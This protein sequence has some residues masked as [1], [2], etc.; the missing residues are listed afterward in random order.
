MKT[1]VAVFFFFTVVFAK[2]YAFIES[3]YSLALDKT[4][5]QKGTIDFGKDELV[6]YY[7]KADAKICYKEG[8]VEL[9]RGGGRVELDTSQEIS[10]AKL[11]GILLKLYNNNEAYLE[12]FFTISKKPG[13]VIYTAKEKLKGYVTSIEKYSSAGEVKKI[14]IFLTNG[15]IL[16]LEIEHEVS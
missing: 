14:T 7:D 6:I 3:R 8:A 2:E 13:V 5:I 15:D 12:A 16:S 9:F 1:V 10:L 11:F 4:L